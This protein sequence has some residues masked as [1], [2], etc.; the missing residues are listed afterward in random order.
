MRAGI[1]LNASESIKPQGRLL[2]TGQIKEMNLYQSNPAAAHLLL[3]NMAH[4][5]V[6]R[7]LTHLDMTSCDIGHTTN[8]LSKQTELLQQ[9]ECLQFTFDRDGDVYEDFGEAG[10]EPVCIKLNP[11][12]VAVNLITSLTK[13]STIRELSLSDLNGFGFEDCKVLSELLASSRYIQMIDIGDN[14][15]SSDSM[16]LIVDG[17]S[18]NTSLEKLKIWYNPIRSEGAVA[19]ANMLATNKSLAELNM[20]RCSIQGEGAVC[21]AKAMERN[22]TLR[23]FDID[24]NPI[25]SEGAVAFASMLKKNQCLKKLDLSHSSVGV[26]G[27]LELIESLKHNT[28]LEKL[29]L[30]GKCEPPSFS[31]LDKTLQDCVTFS[32]V[33]TII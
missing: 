31:T 12:G 7:K 9:L 21:L 32:Q 33:Y 8:H 5:L 28:T 19:F 22:S 16:Q 14:G 15:L 20:R 26:E 29:V 27:A 18:R 4:L 2:S 11:G 24:N 23:E 1:S 17:L 10:I 25:G 30:S 3:D 13:F 6:F